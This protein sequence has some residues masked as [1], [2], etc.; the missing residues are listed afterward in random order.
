[1]MNEPTHLYFRPKYKLLNNIVFGLQLPAA[2]PHKS[3]TG[4]SQTGP[5]VVDSLTRKGLDQGFAN[6]DLRQNHPEGCQNHSLCVPAPGCRCS[7]SQ[8]GPDNLQF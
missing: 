7:R 6:A 3:R 1:M 2:A 8:V 4:P 5:R